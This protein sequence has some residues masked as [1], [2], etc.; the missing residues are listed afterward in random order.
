MHQAELIL[1]NN[2]LKQNKVERRA[3]GSCSA[4]RGETV[5]VAEVETFW[6]SRIKA[7]R[8]RVLA[9]P[10]L[11]RDLTARQNVILTQELRACLNELAD[12]KI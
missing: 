7:F 12:D 3:G 5:L 2:W 11:V 6:R 9:V 1:L 4:L 10:S 8:N